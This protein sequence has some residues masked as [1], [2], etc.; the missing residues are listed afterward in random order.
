[1]PLV[2][3]TKVWGFDPGTYPAL[4]FNT[5]GGRRK[6]LKES[7]PGDWV[8]LAGT[9]GAPTDPIDQ[10]RLLG[11]VQLGPEEVDVEEV[12]RSVGTPIPEDHYNEDGRYRWP[13]GLPFI[14]AERFPEKPDLAEV[15]GDYLP[16]KQWA[17]YALDVGRTL[18]PNMQTHLENLRTERAHIIDAPAIIRQ[19]ERQHALL[20]NQNRNLTGPGP[21]TG[22]IGSE[23]VA[24]A[25]SAYLF[26]LQGG[27]RLAYKI[28]YS[29]DVHGRLAE[30]NKGLVP[31]VTGCLWRLAMRQE[32]ETE[33][34]AYEFEQILH[35]RLRQHRVEGEQEVYSMKLDDLKRAWADE[36]VN[37]EWAMSSDT[38]TMN[39]ALSIR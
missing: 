18:G 32:F 27:R 11:K 12:V 10:G 30:L 2:F 24:G 17:S 37:A 8:V 4:G 22:R 19:R 35:R 5:E 34:H 36:L 3:L 7:S 14:A 15:L 33:N 29:G 25:A 20:L 1:M 31:S 38:S 39:P 16:G 9:R 6:F 26:E 13:F 23:R 21:S 28:G